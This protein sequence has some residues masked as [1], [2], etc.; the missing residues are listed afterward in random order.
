MSGSQGSAFKPARALAAWLLTT[1]LIAACSAPF[2][3]DMS[4][5]SEASAAGTG[6]LSLSAGLEGEAGVG[7]LTV[8]PS[9]DHSSITAYRFTLSDGPGGVEAPAPQL[10]PADEAGYLAEPVEFRDL[11][12]GGW[13][14]SVTALKNAEDD[15]SVVLSG[16]AVV[17]VSAGAFAAETITLRPFAEGTG[18]YEITLEWP[19][20]L[21]PEVLSVRYRVD[22]GSWDGEWLS[23]DTETFEERPVGMTAAVI[24]DDNRE[25]GPFWLTVRIDHN[26]AVIDELV[27]VSANMTSAETFTFSQND[28]STFYVSEEAI[29]Q[30]IDTVIVGDGEG[31]GGTAGFQVADGQDGTYEYVGQGGG[32]L[33]FDR[34]EATGLIRFEVRNDDGGGRDGRVEIK[35]PDGAGGFDAPAELVFIL[36]GSDDPPEDREFVT[37]EF[38]IPE[39][40]F[41]IFFQGGGRDYTFRNFE[42][43]LDG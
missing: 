2:G 29:I 39:T 34:I 20:D 30:D 43:V 6:G 15:D 5:P 10:K 37:V 27:Y 16:A 7:A 4:N 41:H 38:A 31:N 42:V 13:T 22:D 40:E 1:A 17:R 14:V 11:V 35:L 12:P 9:M 23:V 18:A 25:A 3:A 26:R 32:T 19:S 21:D 33:E 36:P 28:F 8:L 24:S